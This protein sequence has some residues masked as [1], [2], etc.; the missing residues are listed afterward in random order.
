MTDKQRELNKQYVDLCVKLGDVSAKLMFNS[1]ARKDLNNQ[2]IAIKEEI[3][4]LNEQMVEA[5][6]E[7]DQSTPIS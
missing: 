3:N 7:A 5:T 4:R 2:A 1:A 6:N